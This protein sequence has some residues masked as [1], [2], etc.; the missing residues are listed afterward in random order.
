MMMSQLNAS[1][2]H[3]Q[4]IYSL[5]GGED[6]VYKLVNTFYDIIEAHPD[7]KK[8]HVMPLRDKAIPH[9]RIEQFNLLSG[10]LA[11]PN[12]YIKKHRGLN[13]KSIHEP[14]EIDNEAK[15][16]WLQCMSLAIDK[17]GINSEI[18]DKLMP[19]FTSIVNLLIN[20]ND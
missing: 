16:I 13:A 9:S 7:G 10:F 14:I 1:D 19:N 12:L 11:G 20:Q 4:S 18:K 3:N 2:V 17:I 5:A 15:D 8:L 6:A